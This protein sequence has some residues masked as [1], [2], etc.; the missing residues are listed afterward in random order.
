MN[1]KIPLRKANVLAVDDQRAN[2]V[3]LDAVLGADYNLIFAGS[4]FEALSVLKERQDV[5]LILMDLQMPGM[6]GFETASRVKQ[7]EGCQDI[8]VVFITAVFNED[9]YIKQGYK[10]GAVDYFSKPFDPEILKVK[11]GIYS[12]FR[13]RAD[14][15]RERERQIQASEELREVGRELSTMLKSL[16]VGVIVADASGRV[17]QTN[18][19]VFS[20]CKSHD[21]VGDESTG[22]MHGWWDAEGTVVEGQLGPLARALLGE[23]CHNEFLDV[24]CHDGIVKTILCSASPLRGR[25]GTIAGAVLV[26]QDLTERKRLEKDLE[27]RIAHLVSAGAELEPGD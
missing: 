12:S 15:L 23:S 3:A 1:L 24:P 4:G 21:P 14:I 16:R 2:L 11:V 9:P 17:C 18:E 19:E 10:V 26:I 7:M 27:R 20:I 13:Q 6:D 25:D 5:D 22:E 8:P